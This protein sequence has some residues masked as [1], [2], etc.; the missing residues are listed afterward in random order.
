VE[1]GV[2]GYVVSGAESAAAAVDRIDGLDRAAC[3]ARVERLFSVDAMVKGYLSVYE[4][5]LGAEA[6]GRKRP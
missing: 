3:R 6:V 4:R 5:V 2:T 1:D